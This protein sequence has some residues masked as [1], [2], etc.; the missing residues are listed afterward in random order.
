VARH[1]CYN[2]GVLA[3]CLRP[4][5]HRA[6][7]AKFAPNSRRGEFLSSVR[8]SPIEAYLSQGRRWGWDGA[9]LESVSGFSQDPIGYRGGFNLYEYVGDDP[10][11]RTDPSG[12]ILEIT[13]YFKDLLNKLCPEGKFKAN[14]S[15]IVYPTDPNFCKGHM[16]GNDWV[17]PDSWGSK[18][19][20]SC[21]CICNA[22]NSS[23]LF[24]LRRRRSAGGDIRLEGGTIVVAIGPGREGGYT[25]S[26]D[27]SCPAGT[28]RSEPWLILAHEL[29]GHEVP[30]VVG[31]VIIGAVGE[32]NCIRREHSC[33][34]DNLGIRDGKD[35]GGDVI[36]K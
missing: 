13:D 10:L 31:G 24:R 9:S 3:S 34:S 21:T 7:A 22:I 23:K 19:P 16:V 30:A 14:S 8:C 12:N 18:T 6:I 17:G 11:I 32:E 27:T 36:L 26:G 25:G 4:P 1:C 33:K 2:G 35:H 29:C 20:N 15:G 5:T 28:V